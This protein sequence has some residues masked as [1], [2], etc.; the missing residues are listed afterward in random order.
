MVCKA[1]DVLYGDFASRLDDKFGEAF[2]WTHMM[3]ST[4]S[5]K[6][7]NGLGVLTIRQKVLLRQEYECYTTRLL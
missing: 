1:I 5:V 3:P 6:R 7:V 2:E 4:R